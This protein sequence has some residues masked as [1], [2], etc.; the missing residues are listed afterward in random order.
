MEW[1]VSEMLRKY[2]VFQIV[3]YLHMHNKVCLEVEFIFK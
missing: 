3:E 2:F 1:V